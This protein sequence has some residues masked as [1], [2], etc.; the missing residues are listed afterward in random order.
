MVITCTPITGISISNLLTPAALYPLRLKH[1]RK[2]HFAV[3]VSLDFSVG[4]VCVRKCVCVHVF[5]CAHAYVMPMY[6]STQYVVS[7]CA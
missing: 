3:A 7:V 4:Y 6:V 1:M 5:E 2:S